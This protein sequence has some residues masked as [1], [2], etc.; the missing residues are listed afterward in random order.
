MPLHRYLVAAHL[1]RGDPGLRIIP[2]QIVLQTCFHRLIPL[3]FGLLLLYFLF[4]FGGHSPKAQIADIKRN[5]G[6]VA[7]IQ[8]KVVA[9]PTPGTIPDGKIQVVRP[10]F[11]LGGSFEG[12]RAVRTLFGNRSAQKDLE[13]IH[14]LR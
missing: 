13:K 2:R 6:P 12:F 4:F 14:P 7:E 5:A 11:P 10:R 9:R 3:F 1:Y 8:T